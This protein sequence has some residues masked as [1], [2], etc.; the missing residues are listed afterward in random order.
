[1]DR[2]HKAYVLELVQQA[3]NDDKFKAKL[4]ESLG[5]FGVNRLE[6]VEEILTAE[7]QERKAA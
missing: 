1:M 5:V 3:L 4:I 2:L 6:E 7:F